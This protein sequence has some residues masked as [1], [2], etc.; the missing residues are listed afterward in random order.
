MKFLF[1]FFAM[2]FSCLSFG[3]NP[4][5][6]YEI[7]HFVDINRQLINGYS[8]FDYEPEKTLDV[9][10]VI[11]DNFTDGYYI[12]N[13]GSKI[14]GLLK[15]SIQERDLKFKL[16]KDD[17]EKSIV[18]DECNGYI[19]G[20]DSFAVVRNV[21]IV[22]VFGDS[23][24][25]KGEFAEFMGKVDGISFYKFIA[26]GANGS[27]VKYVVKASD[28]SD[29]LTFPSGSGKFKK[30]AIEIFG[31]D[32]TLKTDIEKGKYEVK[33]IPSLIKI[34]KYRK[35]FERNQNILYNKSWDETDNPKESSYYAKIESVKDSVFHLSYFFNND[36]K[37][38]EGDFTSFYPHKKRGTF[39][40]YYPNGN[41][42]KKVNFANNKPKNEIEYF[43]NQKIH[44]I[45]KQMF[46]ED[47]RIYDQVNNQQGES[48]LDAEGNGKE[49]FFD[50]VQGR[51]ITYEYIKYFL[52][53]IYYLDK[54]G[55]MIYQF[56][57]KN[58]KFTDL[59]DLQKSIS[60]NF[61]YPAEAINKYIHGYALFK[62][63]VEP[64]GLVSE[65]QLLKGVDLASDIAI[66][67]F[68][69]CLKTKAYWKPGKVNGVF[70]RQEI[71]IPIDF[72]I[73]GFSAFKNHYNNSWHFH[74]MMFQQQMMNQQQWMNQ[75][76][77]KVPTGRF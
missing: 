7:G 67:D 29:Y 68:L 44:R 50:V 14:K 51:E 66:T 5:P 38:Y 52:E 21:D 61:K 22:G 28:S 54:N 71:V 11:G 42:R 56:C 20:V 13:N 34:F 76:M 25:K 2:L 75:Q 18:A 9:A 62:C 37:I 10:Y 69:S 17:P 43:L 4:I 15:Y 63:I 24:S 77:M 40:F 16:G 31:S 39:V 49:V 33:D 27:Y 26:L 64:T 57:Q 19:I 48:V 32:S 70:V 74:Q 58:A 8:D 3:Q 45:S 55:E 65:V 30:M 36:V 1:Y 72:S 60:T 6:N 53:N 59:K 47:R 23:P 73:I 41:I 46:T 35:L 12:D